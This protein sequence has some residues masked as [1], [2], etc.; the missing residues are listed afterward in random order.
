MREREK[1]RENK[2]MRERRGKGEDCKQR[3][4][5]MDTTKTKNLSLFQRIWNKC[6]EK[7]Q[8]KE[9]KSAV[10]RKLKIQEA[11]LRDYFCYK[12]QKNLFFDSKTACMYVLK[13]NRMQQKP[14]PEI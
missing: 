6:Q 9:Y 5:P 1:D 4:L 13:D 11:T 10:F 8:L 7:Y 3:A 14:L 12:V 2:R